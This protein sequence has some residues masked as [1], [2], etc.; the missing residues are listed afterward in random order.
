MAKKSE[1]KL[2]PCGHRT[3]W[4]LNQASGCI[5]ESHGPIGAAEAKAIVE[6]ARRGKVKK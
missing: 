4:K 5:H 1:V 6:R 2:L 3:Y